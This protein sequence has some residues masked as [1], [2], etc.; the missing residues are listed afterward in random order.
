V[1]ASHGKHGSSLSI[2][3]EQFKIKK[4]KID[5]DARALASNV[6]PSGPPKEE[7]S[8]KAAAPT[9]GK[10]VEQKSGSKTSPTK[11]AE[12][13]PDKSSRRTDS[14][15]K[16]NTPRQ[17][18]FEKRKPRH[19]SVRTEEDDDAQAKDEEDEPLWTPGTGPGTAMD[20][21]FLLPPEGAATSSHSLPSVS[22]GVG[23]QSPGLSLGMA[24]Y[25]TGSENHKDQMETIDEHNDAGLSAEE[26]ASM[27]ASTPARTYS[28]G[29]S[30]KI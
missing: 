7:K 29:A 18:E 5:R 3:S 8:E 20:E 14:K 26:V 13:S 30:P 23:L 19:M 17:S 15:S 28:A 11:S 25:L 2:E 10:Q 21:L 22:P 6:Q 16:E 24:D 27:M 4:R 1:I 9:K 12:S